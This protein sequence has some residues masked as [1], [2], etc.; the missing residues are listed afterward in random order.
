MTI[1]LDYNA[2]TPIDPRVSEAMLPY[3]FEHFGNPSSNHVF[4]K[5]PKEAIHKSRSQLAS[6]IGASFS[7]EIVFVGSGSEGNNLAIQGV[8]FANQQKGKHIITSS[9]EHPAVLDTCEYLK[10]VHGFEISYAAVDSYGQVDPLE[11]EQLIRKDTILITIM[12][13]NNETGTI[14]PIARIGEI[15]RKYNIIF[16]SDAAQSIGKVAVNVEELKVD[17]LTIVGH[18]FYAPKGIGALYIRRGTLL[19][20]QIRGA[21]QE[22]GYRAGTENVPYIVA[23]GE[24]AKWAEQELISRSQHFLSLRDQFH[25]TLI[26]GLSGVYLNGHPTIR[27][28]NTLNISIDGIVGYELLDQLPELAASTGSACHS[29]QLNYSDVL[30]AMGISDNHAISAL[31]FSIGT[32]T[33]ED[34]IKKASKSIIDAVLKQKV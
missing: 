8:A 4:G 22:F 25:Q 18:K 27:L 10:D 26:S 13:S 32:L 30:K 28:P 34:D 20:R 16:H 24:A 31:R 1:Y 7:D 12:H 19:E 23:L 33:T 5:I 17:L 15:A 6:L 2:T 11:I 21:K 9:I 14:Q 29:G 3:I